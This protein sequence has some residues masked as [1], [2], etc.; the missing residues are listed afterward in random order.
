MKP[1]SSASV[2]A[3]AFF[4]SRPGSGWFMDHSHSS[5]LS[6]GILSMHHFH[7]Q[8]RKRC[9]GNRIRSTLA[10]SASMSAQCSVAMT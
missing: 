6:L 8:F 1:D 2:G 5:S 4:F 10:Y 9:G 7:T 3:G